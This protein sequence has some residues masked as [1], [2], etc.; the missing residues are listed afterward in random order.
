MRYRFMSLLVSLLSCG[1]LLVALEPHESFGQEKKPLTNTDV[2]KMVENNLGEPIILR[3]IEVN[4]ANFDVSL[5]GLL[6]L[7]Q[8]G[9][10]QKLIE[11][12][13]AAEG[14]KRSLPSQPVPTERVASGPSATA[15]LL[16][17]DTK[18]TLVSAVTR[19]AQ[20]KSKGDSMAEV[21]RDSAVDA[22]LER[23]GMNAV[24]AAVI[25]TGGSSW[26]QV[27]IPGA[28]FPIVSRFLTRAP[29]VTYVWAL[30]GR[31]SATVLNGGP[32]TFELTYA[33][34]PDVNADDFQPVIVKLTPTAAN[35][36]LVG[37]TKGKLDSYQTG[38]RD[39]AVYSNFLEERVTARVTRLGRGHVRVATEQPLPPGEYGLAL[40]PI[41]KQKKFSGT[42]VADGQGEGIL[43]NSVWDFAIR[44]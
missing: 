34:I 43:F 33:D 3:A 42:D 39:W 24:A 12:M 17:G 25:A 38:A 30:P 40:R 5:D 37:A 15:F 22:V 6:Q 13:L 2:M 26:A 14:A 44:H 16:E 28:A 4:G 11:V 8:A 9:V 20:T 29:T 27:A 1:A 19:M 31:A 10:S 23:V 41:S 21:A 7:K 18:R 36:R 32:T 35:W